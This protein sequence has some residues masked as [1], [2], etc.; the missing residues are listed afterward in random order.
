MPSDPTKR[1]NNYTYGVNPMR[2]MEDVTAKKPSMVA[3]VTVRFAD[4]YQIEQL[5]KGVLATEAASAIQ[6]PFFQDFAREVYAKRRTFPGG[7]QLNGE[8]ALL[9][10]KWKG[11]G[12][13][14]SILIK[15]RDAVFSI[16]APGAP[17]PG[18]P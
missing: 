8:I 7:A 2:I 16:P 13:T 11:R 6:S 14:E 18:A 17:P 4:L 12:L 5:V 1:L 15:V 10:A 3:Q 9:L